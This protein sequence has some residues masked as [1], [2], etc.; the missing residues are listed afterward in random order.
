MNEV[1]FIVVKGSDFYNAYFEAKAEKQNF[2]NLAR[3]FLKKNGLLDSGEYYQRKFLGLKLNKDQ[4]EL[5]KEQ[6][7]KYP[8]ENGLSLFKK[9]SAM[10]KSWNE[11][12]TDKVNFDTI[13]KIQFWWMSIIVC[14]T[15]SLWDTGENIY[16]YLKNNEKKE[17]ILP[18][19]MVK[20]KMSEYYSVIESIEEEQNNA[21]NISIY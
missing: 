1:A 9:N 4:R 5:Y 15:Y 6:L 21:Q 13:N 18:E 7:K 19:Y 10:Q 2:H 11:E 12:V 8:D 17:I 3:E 16:G 20:I 14:G